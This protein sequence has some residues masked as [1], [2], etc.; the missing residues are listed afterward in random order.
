M[1]HRTNFASFRTFKSLVIA[2]PLAILPSCGIFGDSDPTLSQ[3]DV[4]VGSVERVHVDAE[5]ARE[6]AH[7]AMDRLVAIASSNFGNDPVL[8]YQD[9]V[10]AI[11]KSE[12]QNKAL[13]RSVAT[14]QAASG[15][16]FEQWSQDLMN[17]N[18]TSM[19]LR[20]QNRLLETQARYEDVVANVI[21]AQK[22]LKDLNAQ[23]RDH[24][25][26]LG[27]DFNQ[28]S[29]SA[30]TS[31][32][33]RMTEKSELLSGK[34]DLALQA[35]RAYVETS[36]LPVTATNRSASPMPGGVA[37]RFNEPRQQAPQQRPQSRSEDSQQLRNN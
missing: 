5:L 13:D 1:N 36:G 11:E 33:Q 26:F 34:F 21:P 17:F 19:R 15:P 7:D 6:R 18:S 29:V 3:V 23:L 16:V 30:I 32:V 31:D 12:N 28:A 25:L 35:A 37:P 9:L 2:V 10:N 14:M 24:A 20:S 27:N 8:I 4:L 22:A